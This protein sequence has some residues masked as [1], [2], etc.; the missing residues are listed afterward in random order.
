M[1]KLKYSEAFHPRVAWEC[2]KTTMKKR[3]GRNRFYLFL[4]LSA[5]MA[6]KAPVAGEMV[7]A[8]I[9]TRTRFAWDGVDYSNYN[10]VNLTLKVIGKTI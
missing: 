10:T 4:V 1:Q 9:Y 8:Y 2:I 7:I 3:P 6:V 5:M